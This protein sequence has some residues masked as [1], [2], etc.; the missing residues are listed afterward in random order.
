MG[1]IGNLTHLCPFTTT[2]AATAMVQ[3]RRQIDMLRF[4]STNLKEKI[5]LR[6]QSWLLHHHCCSH[7]CHRQDQAAHA[8]LV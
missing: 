6:Y 2:A 7:Y 1:I 8:A 5:N 4:P 3:G